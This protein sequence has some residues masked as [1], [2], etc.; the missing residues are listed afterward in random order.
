MFRASRPL[1][2]LAGLGLASGAIAQAPVIPNPPAGFAGPADVVTPAPALPSFT[3]LAPA[4]AS[5]PVAES[6]AP[7][8]EAVWN[9]GLFFQTPNKEF[10]AHVGG[11]LHADAAGEGCKRSRGAP[12]SSTTASIRAG[13]GSSSK[14]PFTRTSITNSKSNS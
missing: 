13:S 5:A 2:F 6:M 8:F 3:A 14:G 12:A 10:G 9:N 1:A 7:K 4:I 11:T